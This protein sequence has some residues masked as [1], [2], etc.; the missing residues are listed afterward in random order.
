MFH[1][2]TTPENVRKPKGFLAFSRGVEIEY[3]AMC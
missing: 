3:W 2:Y 1:F